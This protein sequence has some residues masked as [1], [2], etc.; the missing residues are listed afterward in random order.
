MAPRGRVMAGLQGVANIHIN[1]KEGNRRAVCQ[2]KV[3]DA[4]DRCGGRT[5][6]IERLAAAHSSRR[7]PTP[8]CWLQ[9]RERKQNER[10]L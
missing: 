7:R 3:R 2:E 6:R 4:P 8:S 5:S 1:R 10:R 9:G